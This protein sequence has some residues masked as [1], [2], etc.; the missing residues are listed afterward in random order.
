[1]RVTISGPP[2][3]G[4]TT[5]AEMVAERFGMKL[6]LT[7]QI[8]REQAERAG[9]NV[10]DYN[11]LAE[12][13]SSI[14]RKLDEEILRKASTLDNVVIEGR[15]AGHLFYLKKID[16]FRVFLTAA[17]GIRAER[18]AK[19]EDT[20]QEDELDT[21]EKR[22]ESERKRYLEY[23]GIN[24]SDMSVYDLVIDSNEISAIE[25]ADIIANE[26]TKE[27]R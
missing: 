25:A 12:K 13:D 21:I 11:R 22:E 6:L 5:V 17:A 10:H 1:M 16:S 27:S 23:Y 14:D 15:L 24:I 26:I 9:M 20:S 18:I 7:G 19:R 8:F 4:K 3:S 2:G